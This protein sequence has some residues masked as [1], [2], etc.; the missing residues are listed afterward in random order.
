MVRNNA[1][2]HFIFPLP[3]LTPNLNYE[4]SYSIFLN[5]GNATTILRTYST[6]LRRLSARR[7][8]HFDLTGSQTRDLQ[9]TKTTYSITEVAY[10]TDRDEEFT[11]FLVSLGAHMF[12]LK[13]T[14]IQLTHLTVQS[15]QTG[16]WNNKH[17]VRLVLRFE[18][19]IK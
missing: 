17:K 3:T 2:Q 13:L 8:K 1:K 4:A 15:A 9:R 18:G 5:I 14:I 12:T 10:L 19:G 16:S 7:S 11:H 6:V